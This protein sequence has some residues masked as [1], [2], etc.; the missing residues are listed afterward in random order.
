MESLIHPRVGITSD[1]FI[2]HIFQDLTVIIKGKRKFLEVVIDFRQVLSLTVWNLH[3]K[4][5]QN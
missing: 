1:I 5:K 2:L 4:K 3:T